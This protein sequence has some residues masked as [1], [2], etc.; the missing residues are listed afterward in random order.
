LTIGSP[1]TA[2]FP[3]GQA[4]SKAAARRPWSIP[5]FRNHLVERAQNTD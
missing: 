4:M 3:S 1:K 2:E 5:A